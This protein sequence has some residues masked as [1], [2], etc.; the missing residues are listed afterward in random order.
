[1]ALLVLLVD[2][3]PPIQQHGDEATGQHAQDCDNQEPLH[4]PSLT[5]HAL[6]VTIADGERRPIP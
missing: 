5:L 1:M 6:S 3:R 2:A 4:N